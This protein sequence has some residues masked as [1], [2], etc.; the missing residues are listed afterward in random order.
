M[1]LGTLG[2]GDR[3]GATPVTRAGPHGPR[4]P[5]CGQGRP[6]RVSGGRRSLRDTGI[7]SVGRGPSTIPR[8]GGGERPGLPPLLRLE[9]CLLP[10]GNHGSRRRP[11][12]PLLSSGRAIGTRHRRARRRSSKRAADRQP[13]LR[14]P[15]RAGRQAGVLRFHARQRPGHGGV[16]DGRGCRRLRRRLRPRHLP[17]DS[18]AERAAAEKQRRV[19]RIRQRPAGPPLD[20]DA[21]G[22][23][24]HFF[25]NFVDF[26]VA[27]TKECFAP[28]GER[29]YCLPTVYNPVPGWLFRNDGGMFADVTTEAGLAAEFGNGLGGAATDFSGD[30]LTDIHVANDTTPHQLWINAGSD[31]FENATMLAGAAVNGDG[32]VEACM[33]VAV[34]DFDSDGDEDLPSHAQ[35]PGNER[36]L[37]YLN[38]GS[39]RFTD[40]TNHLGMG[41]PSCRTRA[42]GPRG[43]TSTKTGSWTPWSRTA[44]S[45]SWKTSAA[46]NSLSPRRTSFLGAAGAHCTR[47][48][49]PRHGGGSSPG[50]A[51]GGQRAIW[52]WTATR[53]SS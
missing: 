27:N 8:S 15:P 48:G 43:R 10:S 9:G 23:L 26:S 36:T 51:A 33:G 45:R 44:P 29:N 19:V 53:M 34:A 4:A 52:T 24:D 20:Y 11:S 41:A 14:E 2:V 6:D 35:L 12:G 49:A 47:S 13:T 50:S 30:G 1:T 32:R 17:H 38:V 22:D 39:G 5:H 18:G 28:T 21:D 7:R 42:S 46:V 37:P 40:S 3:E 25:A 16:L 31:R